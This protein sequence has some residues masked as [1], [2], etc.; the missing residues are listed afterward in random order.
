M[1][2]ETEPA[3]EAAEWYIGRDGRQTGPMSESELGL[4]VRMG[5]VQPTDLFWRTGLPEWVTAGA[6]RDLIG[7]SDQS[8][9]AARAPPAPS[10][11]PP[12]AHQPERPGQSRAPMAAPA[13][14]AAARVEPVFEARSAP[15]PAAAPG[16]MSA[17][18]AG[19]ALP[20]GPISSR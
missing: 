13:G 19:A 15:L 17:P 2:N 6:L 7:P 8:A 9:A 16:V 10:P 18:P 1:S 14:L 12:P 4:I 5:H 3:A 11:A 20:L